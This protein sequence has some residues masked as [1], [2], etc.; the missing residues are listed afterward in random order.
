MVAMTWLSEMSNLVGDGLKRHGFRQEK[1]ITLGILSFETAKTMSRLVSLYKSLSDEEILKLKNEVVRSQGVS[2]LN[3]KDEGFLLNLACAERLEDLDRSATAIARL[4]QKCSEFCLNR[5]DQ[6]YTDLKLGFVDLAKLDYSSK[7]TEK[8]VAKM[9]R[10]VSA[11]SGL[12]SALEGLTEMEISERKLIQW[13]RN[14]GGPIQSQKAN[15]DLF[16]QKIAWQRKMVK[17]LR[18]LSLWSQTFDRSVA[19]MAR[20]VFVVY[21]RICVVFGPY[22]SVLPRVPA[23]NLRFPLVNQKQMMRVHP[24][25]QHTSKSGPIIKTTKPGLVRFL[26][27]ESNIFFSDDLGFGFGAGFGIG[28]DEIKRFDLLHIGKNNKVLQSAPLS[29][30]GGSGLA[31]RYANI[32]ILAERYLHAPTGVCD[33]ARQELYH[34]LPSSV[35]VSVGAKLRKRRWRKE[36]WVENGDELAEGWREALEEIMGWLAPMAQDTV[37][38]YTERNFEKQKFDAKPTVLLMHTLHFSDKE[39][40]EAAIAEVLVGLSC[41]Y[42]YE[43][44]RSFYW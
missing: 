27:R 30:V 31:L 26:S 23:R 5:F 44:R 40:T 19:Y 7:G 13:K 39:K 4:G 10:L 28:F 24:E 9:E 33:L 37:K 21:A 8:I 17:H 36:D 12:Y 42:R 3:S 16:D 29:T 41:I 15:C 34:M 22:F 11:T 1:P 32:I 14:S 2:Y 25:D 20:I 6:V 43:N 35:R 38:W 18:Q